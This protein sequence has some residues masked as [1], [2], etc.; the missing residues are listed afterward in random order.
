MQITPSDSSGEDVS[1]YIYAAFQIRS[2]LAPINTYIHPQLLCVRLRAVN[3]KRGGC[4]TSMALEGKDVSC[5]FCCPTGVTEM[6]YVDNP[7]DYKT[8]PPCFLAQTEPTGSDFNADLCA[9]KNYYDTLKEHGVDAEIVYLSKKKLPEYCVGNADNPAATGSPYLGKGSVLPKEGMMGPPCID[10]VSAFADMVEPATRFLLCALHGDGHEAC[11]KSPPSP[12]PSPPCSSVL[13]KLC[14]SA[15]R[16]S[17]GNC[18][19]CT[20]H[21]SNAPQLKAAGCAEADFESFC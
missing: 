13:Q 8:H 11:G 17:T 3:M 6:Y 18:L 10:H 20:A 21:G 4:S 12:P 2:R 1:I 15:K 19:V 7:D 5:E 14:G 9:S 16:A